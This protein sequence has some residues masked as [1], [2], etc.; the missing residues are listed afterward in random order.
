MGG[1]SV[2][3]VRGQ[4]R[5]V[6]AE[7]Q[8]PEEFG[9]HGS[10]P[11]AGRGP[12]EVAVLALARVQPLCQTP[13]LRE[14]AHR[15]VSCDRPCWTGS[16]PEAAAAGR[17]AGL[18]GLARGARPEA[19]AAPGKPPPDQ[20]LGVVAQE[21]LG[22]PQRQGRPWFRSP[23]NEDSRHD[24]QYPFRAAGR[25]RRA[26]QA[27]FRQGLP[28]AQGQPHADRHQ[29]LPGLPAPARQRVGGGP[30]RAQPL[31]RRRADPRRGRQPRRRGGAR[32]NPRRQLAAQRQQG[33][34]QRQT[35]RRGVPAA[36]R[37]Q[38]GDPCAH[39]LPGRLGQRPPGAADP[40]RR[41]AAGHPGP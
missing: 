14:A 11:D 26:G 16:S 28:R 30:A 8:A 17:A 25:L 33:R 1:A 23:P 9:T 37:G 35:L 19:C 3:L 21:L 24:Q 31:G 10:T 27:G 12:R 4:L 36:V 18:S 34:R 6:A 29:Y 15:G 32:R 41:V 7:G 2:V 5:A 13:E 22:K 40:L 39:A 20:G 38:R